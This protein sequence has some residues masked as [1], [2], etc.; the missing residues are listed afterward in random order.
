MIKY[1][2]TEMLKK[3]A[4]E[5]K[6]KKLMSGSVTLKRAALSFLDD[7]DFISK[8]NIANV[9]LKT[10]KSYRKRIKA[11]SELESELEKKPAQLIQRVQNAIV[12]EI[13]GEIKNKYRGEMYRWLP[14]DADEADPEHQLL[15]GKV[16]NMGE[17]DS[18]G[19]IPGE[20]YGCRCGM[21][22]LTDEE[23]LNL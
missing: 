22:I 20:R 23:K 1:D 19:N 13:S 12:Y 6:I 11:D 5:K 4:P 18:E 7:V 15:Y 10:L 14:S 21:E 2:P 9:A 16:F 3:I 8:K 17:G